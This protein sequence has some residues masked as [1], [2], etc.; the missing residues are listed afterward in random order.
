VLLPHQSV[1]PGLRTTGLKAEDRAS[2]T[3]TPTAATI[4]CRHKTQ[5][6]PPAYGIM[7]QA[8]V[9]FKLLPLHP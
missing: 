1:Q 8:T 2:A 4:M 9:G 5:L 3:W 6:N 7:V